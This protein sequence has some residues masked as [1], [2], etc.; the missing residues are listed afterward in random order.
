VTLVASLRRSRGGFVGGGGAVTSVGAAAGF[1]LGV[2][3]APVLIA[4]VVV[5]PAVVGGVAVS[6]IF[7]GVHQRSQLGLERALD[8]LERHPTLQPS[9]HRERPRAIGRDL[10]EV[11]LQISKEVKRAFEDKK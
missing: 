4:G 9:E 10:G 7:R 3:G 5:L 8:E 2:L 11:M 6:R 1:V